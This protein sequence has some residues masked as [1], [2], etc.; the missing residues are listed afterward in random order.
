[1]G[2]EYEFDRK[3]LEKTRCFFNL[4]ILISDLAAGGGFIFN[5]FVEKKFLFD[6]S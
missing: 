2:I 4:N 1:M 3:H 6:K 5:K